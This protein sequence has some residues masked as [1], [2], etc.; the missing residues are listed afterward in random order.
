MTRLYYSI[1]IGFGF[2]LYFLLAM[3]WC[4]RNPQNYSDEFKY[5]LVRRLVFRLNKIA[6]IKVDV[7]GLENLPDEGGYIM[8]ANHQGRY[9]PSGVITVHAKP[10][11]IVIDAE[12]A[13]LPL[14]RQVAGVLQAK[15]FVRGDLRQNA[16]QGKL[17]VDEVKEGRRYLIFPEGIYDDNKNTLKEFRSGA[18]NFAKRAHCPIVPV[19]L[20]DSY[21]VFGVNSLRKVY[22][23]VEILP[24]LHFE[25]VRGLTTRAIGE[26]V[27]KMIESRM[28]DE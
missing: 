11:S 19:A 7:S 23:R 9:D 17:M 18:F 5:S 1:T 26:R 12:R 21:K 22:V 3:A 10:L 13:K 24:P 2:A 6:R 4:M 14:M 25:E 8:Y 15:T 27:K 28:P 16:L 20:I